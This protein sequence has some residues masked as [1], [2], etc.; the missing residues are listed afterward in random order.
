MNEKKVSLGQAI[1]Q[2]VSALEG[3]EEKSRLTAV[4][5]ACEFLELSTGTP[6][7][8]I[9][10][11]ST[12]SDTASGSDAKT[13]AS[14]Q[15]PDRKK[16]TGQ[17]VDIRKFKEEKNPG[18]ARQMACVVAY[19]LQELAPTADRKD[20]VSVDDLD[21]YFK[22]AKYPLPEKLSQV[23]IATKNAGYMDSPTRG[24]YKLNAVG[25]NLVAHNLPKLSGV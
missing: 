8:S 24:Q 6:V 22:Q 13:A 20:T 16:E 4:H 5:A 14:N 11:P 7:D 23:L 19:Y 17:Q 12:H 21:K 18:S 15:Y 10:K 1:D 3:L 9:E 2:I 25:Y